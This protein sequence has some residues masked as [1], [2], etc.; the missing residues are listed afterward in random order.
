MNQHT[1]PKFLL[2]N[3]TA[4]KKHRVWVCDKHTGAK[5]RTNRKNVAAERGFYDLVSGTSEVSIEPALAGI[6]ERCAPLVAEIVKRQSLGNI[7]AEARAALSVF[8]AVLLVRT[9]EYRLRFDH[10]GQLAKKRLREAGASR[11]RGVRGVPSRT[12]S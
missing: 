10:L 5:F 9:R 12:R 6:E 3:F 7:G 8:F 11:G 1:V 4:D 2:Q